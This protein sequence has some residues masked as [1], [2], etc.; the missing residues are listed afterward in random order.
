MSRLD[1]AGEA[2]IDWMLRL[3]SGTAGAE[4]HLAFE[5]WL[6]ADPRH[7]A[8]WE[9]LQGGIAPAMDRLADA[10]SRHPGQLQTATRL[11]RQSGISASRRKLLRDG[12]ALALLLG[13]SGLLV[14]QRDRP[15]NGLLADISSRTGERKRLRLDDGSQLVLDARTVVDLAFDRQQRLLRLRQGALLIDVASDTRRPLIVETAEG[16]VR[17]LGTRFSV[18]QTPGHSLVEVQRHSVAITTRNGQRT[19]LE[20]GQAVD[21]ESDRLTP[22]GASSRL[23]AWVDGQLEVSD[24]PLAEVIDNLR[25]YHRGLLR[26]SPAAAELRVFG[27]FPLDDVPRSLQ[28]LKDILP[29]HVRH[30]GPLTL[31]DLA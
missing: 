31:I 25:P 23:S 4:E 9:R 21:F 11:L 20:S 24:Q 29:I 8:A 26:L 10:E 5:R 3:G 22:L 18:R 19:L 7:R 17:A 16:L 27:V 30:Y 15:L 28:A 1:P 6:S 14:T 2:A 12:G 13:A